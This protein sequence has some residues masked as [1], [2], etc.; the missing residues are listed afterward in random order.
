MI[1]P[2]SAYDYHLPDPYR[3]RNNC[4][5]QGLRGDLNGGQVLLFVFLGIFTFWVATRIWKAGVRQYSGASS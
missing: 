3:R 5:L 1:Y 2:P 4:T